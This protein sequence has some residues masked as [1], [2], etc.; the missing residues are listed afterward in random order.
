MAFVRP[1]VRAALDR[2]SDPVVALDRT[3][4]ILVEERP[5][6]LMVTVL[7]G[8]LDVD[9]GQFRFANAGH[10]PP[11]VVR[12]GGRDVQVLDT[13]GPL[14]GAFR[15]LGLSE[16]SVGLERGDSLVLYT[17][18]VTDAATPSGERFGSER[19]ETLVREHCAISA[20]SVV[21]TVMTAVSAWGDGA[22]PADDLA[23]LVL[24]R[25]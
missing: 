11:L 4:R 6:G 23:L 24:R 21:E 16:S 3:N 13:A 8:I 2:T 19:F 14:V 22:E 12:A 1:V 25:A 5:T 17:D 20:S 9:S 18:G 10:E 7:C 15:S